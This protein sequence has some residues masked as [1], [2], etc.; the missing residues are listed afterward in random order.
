[1]SNAPPE[2]A[3]HRRPRRARQA[4]TPA[5]GR[6]LKYSSAA[7]AAWVARSF[8][9]RA[10][11]WASAPFG[12]PSWAWSA[13]PTIVVRSYRASFPNPDRAR[14]GATFPDFGAFSSLAFAPCGARPWQRPALHCPLTSPDVRDQRPR[15]ARALLA[16]RPRP[17]ATTIG[18]AVG[19]R[20]AELV[21]G[22]AALAKRNRR[23]RSACRLRCR[24]EAVAENR[25]PARGGISYAPR[26]NPAR[27]LARLRRGGTTDPRAGGGAREPTTS[28]RTTDVRSRRCTRF[29]PPPSADRLQ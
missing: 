1:M 17:A 22:M 7:T 11:T 24:A 28:T 29:A 5:I 8:R 9:A 12:R 25:T 16:I 13:A 14:D 2:K 26:E 4:S 27:E 19:H 10:V 20:A 23:P 3:A 21:R 6:A 18:R 15:F